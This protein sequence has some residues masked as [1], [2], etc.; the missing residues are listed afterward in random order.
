MVITSV[1]GESRAPR[2]VA[3]SSWDSWN[4][5]RKAWTTWA[6]TS[7]RWLRGMNISIISQSSS[8]YL[9]LM[10]KYKRSDKLENT[11]ACPSSEVNALK[12]NARFPT[13]D[14]SHTP[15]TP[16]PNIK[17]LK[18]SETEWGPVVDEEAITNKNNIKKKSEQVYHNKNKADNIRVSTQLGLWQP[19]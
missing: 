12:G 13:V 3:I 18:Q 15:H 1:I 8:G 11:F 6:L 5:A 10:D 14:G 16:F 17:Q 4:L 2:S 7:R 9:F 19:A